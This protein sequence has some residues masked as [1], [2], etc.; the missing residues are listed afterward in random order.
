MK[1]NFSKF[2]IGIIVTNI[3]IGIIAGILFLVIKDEKSRGFIIGFLAV[4]LL[5]DF[6]ISSVYMTSA[7]H[8]TRSVS[9]VEHTHTILKWSSIVIYSLVGA[10]IIL[11]CIAT[12]FTAGEDIM[13]FFFVG[14]NAFSMIFFLV[15]VIM[16]IFI[17]AISIYALIK[18]MKAPDYSTSSVLQSAVSELITG[19]S[20]MGSAIVGIGGVFIVY[21]VIKFLNKKKASKVNPPPASVNPPPASVNPPP[22]PKVN[23]P[24]PASV[25]PPPPTVN[26]LSSPPP[27]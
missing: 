8:K 25:N 4:V 14:G 17:T 19:L 3:L 9:E 1:V 26:P 10:L 18:F 7:S 20:I 24:P 21:F 16:S 13:F 11:F 22:L 6:L 2:D 12:F 23:P 27:K 15:S 5:I